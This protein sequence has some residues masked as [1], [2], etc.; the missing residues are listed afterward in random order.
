MSDKTEC[1]HCATEVDDHCYE[2]CDG[3]QIER[4]EIEN[5]ELKALFKR[6]IDNIGENEGIDYFDCMSEEDQVELNKID[7]LQAPE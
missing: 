2:C 1:P 7:K 4:L 3:A 5:K 6:Y